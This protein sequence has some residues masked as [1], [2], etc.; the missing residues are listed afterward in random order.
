MQYSCFDLRYHTAMKGTESF[1]D[2][3]RR[4]G[5]FWTERVVPDLKEGKKV[6]IVA[7]GNCLRAL[8]QRVEGRELK[9]AEG[10]E[11]ARA[12]PLHYRFVG[13]EIAAAPVPH[14]QKKST[15]L[16]GRFILPSQELASRLDD[17]REW[18]YQRTQMKT[19]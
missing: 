3:R 15:G 9:D 8:I 4:V 10:V 14:R 6:A 1:S 16:R 5:S 7:H 17:E 18:L 11:V 19:A 13:G 2:M 12:A